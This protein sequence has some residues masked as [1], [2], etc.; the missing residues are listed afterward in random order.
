MDHEG[1]I[2]ALD[3][4]DEHLIAEE[5]EEASLPSAPRLLR[6]ENLRGVP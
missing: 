4:L 1:G 3:L 5:G 6:E 2:A